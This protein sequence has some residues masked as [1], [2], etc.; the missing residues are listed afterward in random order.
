MRNENLRKLVRFR[1]EQA[2]DALRAAHVLL[3][4]HSHRD[5]VNHSYHVMLYTVLALLVTKQRYLKAP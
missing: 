5:A 2:Q 1:I 4:Q 3:D